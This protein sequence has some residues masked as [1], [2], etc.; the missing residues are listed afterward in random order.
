M[1]ELVQNILVYVVIVSV[2][3]GLITNPKYA[4]YFQFFSGLI[5]ILLMLSPLL[6]LFQYENTWYDI[7]EENVLKMDLDEIQGEM[8]I[9]DNSFQDMLQKEYTDTIAEQVTTM[10]QEKGMTL[11][12]VK[13]TLKEEDDEWEIAEI[14]GKTNGETYENKN[15][16]KNDLKTDDK[17]KSNTEEEERISVETIQIGEDSFLQDTDNKE[18]NSKT[19]KSLRKQ[20]S[21]YFVIG[22]DKVHLWK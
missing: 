19:A 21:N 6:S 10:A 8:K 14:T 2:L 18:D 9:A 3:R 4:Q 17:K 7:L 16:N 5:M 11:E 1:K 13:V 22:E 20:I 15:T 12:D